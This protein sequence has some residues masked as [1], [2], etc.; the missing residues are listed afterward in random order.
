MF[1]G[2]AEAAMNFY[3]SIFKNSEIR[4]VTRYDEKGPGKAGSIKLATFALNGR[5]L[6]CVDSPVQ[7]AFG[8]TPAIS[9]FVTCDTEAEIDTLFAKLSEGGQVLMP[10]SNYPFSK[11]FAWI[12]DQFGVSWQL[13]LLAS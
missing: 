10:L 9:L 7:H 5:E 12:N 13:D 11:K 6:M 1:T 2:K 4:S 3:M 8:F